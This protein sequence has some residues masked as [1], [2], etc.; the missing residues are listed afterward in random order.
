MR[1]PPPSVWFWAGLL[2]LACLTGL[3]YDLRVRTAGPEPPVAETRPPLLES[4]GQ[5]NPSQPSALGGRTANP[6]FV[7]AGP[8]GLELAGPAPETIAR[9]ISDT[10]D[11]DD[12]IYLSLRRHGVPEARVLNLIQALRPVFDPRSGS[13][14]G[15]TYI[16]DLG[17]GDSVVRF[18]YTPGAT[19]EM[20]VVITPED[21][22]LVGK[23]L[24]L[25]LDER[26][27]VV[28]L[29]IVD[30]L[31]NAV[32]ASGESEALTDLLADVIFG[33]V[34]D[35]HR[36]PRRGDRIDLVFTKLYKGASFVRYGRVDLARYRGQVAR[37]TAVYHES[38]RSG[39]YYDDEGASLE[40]L[41]LLKPLSFRRISAPFSRQRYHPI[42]KRNRPHL[43]TDYAAAPGTEVMA[44]ARGRVVTAGWNGGYGKMIE[45]EHPNGYRTRYAHL[46]RILV[47]PGQRVGKRQVIGRVGSTGLATGP[48]L[49]Y[50]LLRAGHHINPRTVNRG[51]VGAPLGRE[52]LRSFN[53]RRDAL[54][55]LV[56]TDRD[57]REVATGSSE[58]SR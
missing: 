11:A 40:R 27:R 21:G 6:A 30:N 25:P 19:P 15:D 36:D 38:G 53:S 18:E 47:R 55:E 5:A 54:L 45:V 23:Q 14:P 9:S 43:G 26:T 37:R 22:E 44:T 39:A 16:L 8:A 7:P 35:F 41:F 28:R 49:H 50:E 48:H 17:S 10:L 29:V 3:R 24:L 57:R 46:S 56:G 58:N 33:S 34:I 52:E 31:S 1:Q 32:A 12:S 13:R 4:S 42:L 2:C 51:S 20:P